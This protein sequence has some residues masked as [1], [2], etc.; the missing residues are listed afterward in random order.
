MAMG[1]TEE[2]K[3]KRWYFTTAALAENKLRKEFE[4]K[5]RTLASKRKMIELCRACRQGDRQREGGEVERRRDSG[6]ACDVK[7]QMKTGKFSAKACVCARRDDDDENR[8]ICSL[9]LLHVATR[10]F[11]LSLC[12]HKISRCCT[13]PIGIIETL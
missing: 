5:T 6:T 9:I 10:S 4:N 11:A 7:T 12:S 8:F 1:R 13:F 2:S 3:T